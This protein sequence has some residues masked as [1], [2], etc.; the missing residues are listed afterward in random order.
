[1]PQVLTSLHFCL[2]YTDVLR[3]LTRREN[4]NILKAGWKV[5]SAVQQMAVCALKSRGN[6]HCTPSVT[7]GSRGN[8]LITRIQMEN[9]LRSLNIFFKKNLAIMIKIKQAQRNCY[10]KRLPYFSNE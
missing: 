8:R 7:I 6:N 9:Q 3:V 2:L 1:M 10:R 4:S 5:M